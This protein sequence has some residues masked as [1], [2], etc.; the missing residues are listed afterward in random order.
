MVAGAT[1]RQPGLPTQLPPCRGTWQCTVLR[2]VCPNRGPPPGA[3][4]RQQAGGAQ[5]AHPQA[6]YLVGQWGEVQVGPS[7]WGFGPDLGLLQYTVR[8][9]TRRLVQLKCSSLP[10]WVPGCGMRPR[11]WRD[12]EGNLAPTTGLQ[13]LEA[14]HKRKFAELLQRGFSTGSSGGGSSRRIPLQADQMA[15]YDAPW[16]DPSPERQ[17]VCSGGREGR[18]SRGVTGDS[19]AAAAGCSML[20][21]Q[22]WT[23]RGP[24]GQGGA[25]AWDGDAPWRAA[26]RRSADKRLP[27]PLRVLG[28]RLLH[29]AVKVGG[30]RV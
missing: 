17:H 21:P 25:A 9:A 1:G 11:L 22:Q 8:E 2:G 13:D 27:R 7:V 16:M 6:Y 14:R 12:S 10:G 24:P 19:A 28:W 5:G 23:T 29:A 20:K 18:Y 3:K 26:Y 4:Q 15:A 30:S